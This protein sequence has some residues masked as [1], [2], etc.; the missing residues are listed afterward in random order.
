MALVHRDRHVVDWPGFGFPERWRRLLDF[1]GEEAWIKTEE[2]H[3]GDTLV[4]RAELPGIDPEKD[5]DIT[6]SGGVVHLQAHREQKEEHQ[7][8]RG[9]RSEFRYGDFSR[10][11]ALPGG[12]ASE[13]VTASYA[14]GI[15]EV[16]VPCPEKAEP[17]PHKVPVQKG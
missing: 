3:D 14:N 2:F 5:I 11:I 1:D 8:K 9:Y 15:L 16:R 12:T 17:A 6:I 4:V 13:D 7:D 10:D